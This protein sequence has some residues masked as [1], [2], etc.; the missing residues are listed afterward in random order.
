MVL[1]AASS[2]ANL[3]LQRTSVA[4]ESTNTQKVAFPTVFGHCE[5]YSK[6]WVE[7]KQDLKEREVCELHITSVCGTKRSDFAGFDARQI[8]DK[9]IPRGHK[10]YLFVLNSYR[11]RP[12]SNPQNEVSLLDIFVLAQH[13]QINFLFLFFVVR[14]INLKPLNITLPLTNCPNTK[15]YL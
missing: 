9:W 5:K 13:T 11:N 14:N 3:K 4:L 1:H 6:T 12:Y 7:L 2:R 15:I 10:Y 8:E